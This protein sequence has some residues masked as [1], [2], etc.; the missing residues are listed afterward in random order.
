MSIIDSI[1]NLVQDPPA[2][3]AFELSEAGLAYAS[4]QGSGFQPAFRDFAPGTLVASPLE[5]NLRDSSAVA[6]TL[7]AVFPVNGN[8][9]RRAALILPDYAARLA[10]LD[11]DT[12]PSSAEEQLPLVRFRIKKS[13]PFDV[14]AA[15]VSYY[16]QASKKN[17]VQVVAAT[18]SFE[19]LAR[20]E[21]LFRQAGF[22][23]GEITVAPLALLDMVREP[24]I[25][26]VM[27]LS[28][29]VLT[30]MV[31]DNNAL[32]LVRCVH[33]DEGDAEEVLAVLYPTLAYVEDELAAPP[34]KILHC[35]FGAAPEFLQR[36][37]IPA[38]PLRGK[39]GAPSAFNAGLFGYLER[40]L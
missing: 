9:K 24:G 27:K 18:V 20:Y 1:K 3:Y 8:R 16:V 33:L 30:V 11:F 39:L 13:V 19:V 36:V 35:G 5:D 23:P 22:L 28:G 38:E 6:A 25:C 32:R 26:V 17:R 40:A 12:F 4:A 2:A 37:A 15:Q 21:T 10:V 34:D 7:S 29:L 14:D 31:L